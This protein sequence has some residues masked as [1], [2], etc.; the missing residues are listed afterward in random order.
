MK[1]GDRVN[2]DGKLSGGDPK[3]NCIIESIDRSNKIFNQPMATLEGI[4]HWVSIYEL[5][6]VEENDKQ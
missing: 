5:S 4:D 1:V 2:Y 3:E 6:M